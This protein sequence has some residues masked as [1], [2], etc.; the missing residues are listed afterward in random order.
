MLKHALVL[1]NQEI[2]LATLQHVFLGIFLGYKDAKNVTWCE[3]VL[4][5]R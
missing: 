1:L 2:F 3:V 4:Q 5:K